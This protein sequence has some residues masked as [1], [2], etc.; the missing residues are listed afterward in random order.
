MEVKE[1]DSG[2]KAAP[3]QIFNCIQPSSQGQC[4]CTSRSVRSLSLPSDGV[5]CPLHGC[6]HTL[7]VQNSIQFEADAR[8]SDAKSSESQQSAPTCSRPVSSSSQGCYTKCTKHVHYA[9][10]ESFDISEGHPQPYD[11]STLHRQANHSGDIN[12]YQ[13]RFREPI[14][15]DEADL[16]LNRTRYTNPPERWGRYDD[17]RHEPGSSSDTSRYRTTRGERAD[18]QQRSKS[19]HGE[20]SAQKD[21]IR[22]RDQ[23]R[24]QYEWIRHRFSDW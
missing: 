8:S 2:T 15:V 9:N 4:C 10:P 7:E 17:H 6:I 11:Y 1:A 13:S 23:D 18:T 16:V 14:L 21:P 20:R 24:D 5:C 19:L 12:G 22:W 3:I